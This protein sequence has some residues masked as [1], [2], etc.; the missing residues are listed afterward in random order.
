MKEEIV[1]RSLEE[2]V[3]GGKKGMMLLNLFLL[4]DVP[5]FL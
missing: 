4:R 1:K 3:L 2:V 5:S